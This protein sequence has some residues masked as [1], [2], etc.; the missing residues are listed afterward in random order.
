MVMG[1]HMS[2]T[3]LKDRPLGFQI[4]AVISFFIVLMSIAVSFATAMTLKSLTGIDIN[5]LDYQLLGPLFKMIICIIIICIIVAKVIS[6]TITEPIRYLERKVRFI[7]NKKWNHNIELDRTDE[8]GRLAYSIGRMQDNLEKIDKE[9]EFFLQSISH[10]LK[11]PIMVVKNY[12]HALRE[13]VYIHGS[14]ERT[15]QVIEDE[16]T[17]LGQKIEKLL[18]ISSLDYV[19][20]KEA[21]L[22]PI[23]LSKIVE[24]SVERICGGQN[25]IE[26]KKDLGEWYCDGIYDKLEVALENILE[27]CMR[28]AYSYIHI[29]MRKIEN[30]IGKGYIQTIIVNDGED[31]PE[32]VLSH[33]FDKFYKGSKGKFGFGL[34]ITKRIVEYHKGKISI[35]NK[36]GQVIFTINLPLSVNLYG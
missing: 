31:I 19:L 10:E 26:I 11:T 36:N 34:F 30:H 35:Q 29:E 16:I 22:S 20:E 13:E 25:K 5:I 7:A 27:N 17:A 14:K 8:L 2:K 28:Y 24:S 32:D 18:Y 6:N 4:W 33:L 12:C 1:I 3:K 9:E 21:Q 15:I 23:L